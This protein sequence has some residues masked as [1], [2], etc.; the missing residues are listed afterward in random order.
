MPGAV[1]HPPPHNSTARDD[2]SSFYNFDLYS[3]L[4]RRV[5][6][7]RVSIHESNRDV[8]LDPGTHNFG[9]VDDSDAQVFSRRPDAHV[10][11]IRRVIA[12]TRDEGELASALIVRNRDDSQQKV[13][14][15]HSMASA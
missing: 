9:A 15:R 3:R 2:A 4:K 12:R 8:A 14:A 11:S 10:R 1:F 7:T 13:V 6:H 5:V